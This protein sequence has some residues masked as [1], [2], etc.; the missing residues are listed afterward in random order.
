MKER[1]LEKQGS[2]NSTLD[3]KT[4]EDSV[5]ES[6]T[7]ANVT[8]ISSIDLVQSP[9]LASSTVASKRKKNK[10][11]HMTKK[12]VR[13][14]SSA[15]EVVLM[16]FQTFVTRGNVVDL[17]VGIVMG[18]AFTAIVTSFVADIITPIIGLASGVGKNIDNAFLVIRCGNNALSNV[19]YYCNGATN[20]NYSTIAIANADGALTWNWG[21]FLQTVINFF[22]ISLF[23]YL[24]VKSYTGKYIT[25]EKHA[26]MFINSY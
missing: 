21:R 17:A 19:S 5:L 10:V 24:L 15:A 22:V 26:F 11:I 2:L 23:I 3:D 4:A 13:K 12:G 18:S 20:H 14:V 1:D 7:H 25:C 16:D 8:D 6:D 9:S